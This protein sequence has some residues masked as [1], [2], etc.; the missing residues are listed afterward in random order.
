MESSIPT[1]RNHSSFALALLLTPLPRSIRKC[2][3]SVV[4]QRE[5]MPPLRSRGRDCKSYCSKQRSSRGRSFDPGA[6]LCR[7]DAIH[8]CHVGESLIPSVRHY[9][10]FIGAEKKLVEFGFQHKVWV[11]LCIGTFGPLFWTYFIA[12]CRFQ[13]QSVQARRMYVDPSEVWFLFG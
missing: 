4:G 6:P 10:R 13:V 5:A 2:L 7:S 3:L 11:G 8:R 9:L 1:V 12:G